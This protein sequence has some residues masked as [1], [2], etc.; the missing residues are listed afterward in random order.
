MNIS[1]RA[2][3]FLNQPSTILGLQV[4]RSSSGKFGGATE[5]T[6]DRLVRDGIIVPTFSS[7]IL[8]PGKVYVEKHY[9]KS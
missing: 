1:R 8:E 3:K 5:Q 2:Q 4:G 6:V 9:H 7:V